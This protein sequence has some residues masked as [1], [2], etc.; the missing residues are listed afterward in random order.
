M[1]KLG[2]LEEHLN[3]QYEVPLLES[4]QDGV[5]CYEISEFDAEQLLTPIL[6]P[7]AEVEELEEV[8]SQE[9]INDQNEPKTSPFL[10][11]PAELRNL[12]YEDLFQYPKAGVFVARP[13]TRIDLHRSS[14][15]S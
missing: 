7:L 9:D 12:V 1:G 6:Q 10:N 15:G 13:Y 4:R 14:Q 2:C 5:T 3:R 8:D 11:L